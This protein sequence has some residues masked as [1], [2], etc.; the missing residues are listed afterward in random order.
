MF[1]N[2]FSKIS[3]NTFFT[4]HLR[5]TVSAFSFS[6][7]ANG[8]VLWKKVFLKVDKKTPLVCK[9]FKNMLFTEH[10]WTT[11]SGIFVQCY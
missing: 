3:K 9:I 7:A 6:D 11:A 8:G 1:S 10:P 4:E 5:T 2:E